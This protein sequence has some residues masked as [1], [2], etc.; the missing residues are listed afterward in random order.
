MVSLKNLVTIA[1][2][3]LVPHVWA[4]HVNFDL[5]LTWQKGAPDGNLR[6]MIFMN[7]QFPGP[8]LR[9]EQGDDVEFVVHNNLPFNTTVHFHG[10]EQKNTPW[11]DGVPGLNQKPIQ[12][13]H[14]W[15]YR[16]TAT[17]YGT[18]WYHA[19]G[20]SEIMD[21][22][23]G[24]ISI[25]PGPDVPQPFHLISDNAQDIEAMQRAEKNP[26]LVILSDW[27]H[28][29][30]SEYQKAIEDSR[31]EIFC[32]D[33]ILIN[34][35]GAVYCPGTEKISSVELSYLKTAID[36]QPLSDK[37]CLPNIYNIQGDFPPTYEDRIPSG[38]NSGCSATTGL[39]EIIEV[40][41]N[42]SWVSL[43]FISASSLKA[44]MFSIDEHPMYIY[45]VD[46]SYIEPQLVESVPIYN[47][48]R[49]AAMIKLDKARKD[50]T[51]RVPDTQ[52]DQVISGFA[53]MRYKGSNDATASNPY[54]DYGGR[55]TSASVTSLNNK[56]IKP[57]P[58]VTIPQAADQLVNLTIGRVGSSYTWTT[59]GGGLYDMMANWDDP[60]L[61]DI[62]AK[63]NLDPRTVIQ[64]K[65]GTWVDLLLQLGEMPHTPASQVSHVMHKHS[66]K[67]FILGVG[68]GYFDWDSTEEALAEHPEFFQMENPQMRD[69][70]VTNG[71]NGPTWMIL[72]YQVVN[73]GPFIFHCHIE[74]HMANGMAVAILDGVDAWPEIPAGED[75]SPGANV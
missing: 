7:D 21:G 47:G 67:A 12:P 65:N 55:N 14:S 48:E 15:T 43:K 56:G 19:H 41:P 44:L 53:T 58:A 71:S 50:Y 31:L 66:N 63:D 68:P 28:L 39:H 13:G 37:G 40:D 23:Y 59:S 64:T 62:D 6:E 74:T 10:I 46:G 29:T 26:Q 9:L 75:Q 22:L 33:S 3:G 34:G 36:N 11:S 5:D 70:F 2:T 16:W 54:V 18:Y 57:Y 45:E 51:I 17:Q 25:N 72:R 69:T 4:K 52:G 30:S 27:D 61:Y 1:A 42:A 24:P 8:E 35:R 60:I 32:S 73:P 38:V 49:Y 20:M